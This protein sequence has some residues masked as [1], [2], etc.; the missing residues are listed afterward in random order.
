MN[1][2]MLQGNE[3]YS[4]RV[5]VILFF[6]IYIAFLEWGIVHFSPNMDEAANIAAGI[7]IWRYGCFDLYPVNP[8]LVKLVAAIQI[9]Y[10]AG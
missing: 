10:L 9:R 8:S 1:E 3:F 6:T 2:K 4:H 5:L 7:S